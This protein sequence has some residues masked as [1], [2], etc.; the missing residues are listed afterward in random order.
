LE[1]VPIACGF[2]GCP[3]NAI[4]VDPLWEHPVCLGH[5]MDRNKLIPLDDWQT[6]KVA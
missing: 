1:S 2:K 3:D 4:G 6:G 5:C